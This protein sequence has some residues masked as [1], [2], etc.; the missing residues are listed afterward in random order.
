MSSEAQVEAN[1]RNAQKSTGPRT[2]EGK[3][4]VAANAITHGLLAEKAFI[5]GEDAELFEAHCLSMKESFAPVGA[6][7]EMLAD[8]VAAQ[9]WRLRRAPAVEVSPAAPAVEVS[10]AQAQA[11]AA[12]RE[13]REH[14]MYRF[15]DICVPKL[16]VLRRY[17]RAIDL[18][19]HQAL[20]D[21]FTLQD[22]RRKAAPPEL[23]RGREL[24]D[25]INRDPEAARLMRQFARDTYEQARREA[26][27]EI[28][29]KLN[30]DC[31]SA[32]SPRDCP[33]S[34]PSQPSD[35]PRSA[36][37]ERVQSPAEAAGERVQSPAEAAGYSPLSP[38]PLSPSPLPPSAGAQVTAQQVVK[39]VAPSAGT[40]CETKPI[41]PAAA[42][43]G[44]RV[45]DGK[46]VMAEIREAIAAA[47]AGV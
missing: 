30:G 47:A 15:F 40:S 43:S 35:C 37:G 2:P 21:L 14:A 6:A 26:M 42:R 1:R 20:R 36:E 28:A 17:E 13:R 39:K 32:S 22:V 41:S 33:R 9:A 8:R 27:V 45:R 29:A 19:L 5:N 3:A 11:M 12:R 23:P 7:E 34:S 46:T 16:D 4:R 18:A 44:R 10:P 25:A 24:V 38:S 31:T